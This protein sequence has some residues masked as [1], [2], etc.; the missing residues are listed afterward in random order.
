MASDFAPLF[1]SPVGYET[2]KLHRLLIDF[3]VQVGRPCNF[4]VSHPLQK[5]E[6][7]WRDYRN[8]KRRL[9]KSPRMVE[10]Q[11]LQ[12]QYICHHIRSFQLMTLES[13]GTCIPE[14]HW[15]VA[16]RLSIRSLEGRPCQLT[17][18]LRLI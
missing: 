8:I 9:L 12:E 11:I 10:M 7:I 1:L 15:L 14:P 18:R 4:T 5:R 13:Q 16:D 17:S 3:Q 2:S 6:S